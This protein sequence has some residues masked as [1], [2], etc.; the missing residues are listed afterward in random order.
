MDLY[1]R[2]L[3]IVT[4]EEEEVDVIHEVGDD[5]SESEDEAEAQ[6]HHHHQ[7][8]LYFSYRVKR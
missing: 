1:R 4:D 8:H 5:D 7:V 2:L 3:E 6:H